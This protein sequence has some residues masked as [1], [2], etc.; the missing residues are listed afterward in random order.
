MV[1]VKRSQALFLQSLRQEL[2][3]N[4]PVSSR[5]LARLSPFIDSA[6]IIRV[7]ERLRHFLRTNRHKFPILLL[8]LSHLSFL[9]ARHWHFYSCHSGPCLMSAM[10]CRQFWIEGERHVIRRVISECTTCVRLAASNPQ[11]IMADF[12]V[13]P[14]APFAR[15]GIDYAGPLLMKKT[16]LICRPKLFWRLSIGLLRIGDYFRRC[17][18]IMVQIS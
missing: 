4:R 13:Q 17:T 10:I 7:G 1:V 15:V 9:I 18:L 6:G 3:S 8:K 16:S 11:P 5:Y 14:S 12:R 2:L